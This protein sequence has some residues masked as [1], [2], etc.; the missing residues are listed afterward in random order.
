MG[1]PA[2][3]LHPAIDGYLQ[4]L[5]IPGFEWSREN[6]EMWLRGLT[7]TLNLVYPLPIKERYSAPVSEP[8]QAQ[9]GEHDG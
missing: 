7:A 3:S 6:R 1:D 8:E 5:P 4:L 2:Y 9:E